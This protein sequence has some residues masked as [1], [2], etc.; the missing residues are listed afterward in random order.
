MS[1]GGKP[2]AYM[3]QL[4]DALGWNHGT[5]IPLANPANQELETQLINRCWIVHI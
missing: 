5:R 4:L 3:E 1:D 2:P